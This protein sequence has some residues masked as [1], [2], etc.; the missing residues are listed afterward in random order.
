MGR[1]LRPR[2]IKQRR[3][4]WAEDLN[5]QGAGEAQRQR[6][7]AFAGFVSLRR[8]PLN[9]GGYDSGGAY[10]GHGAPLWSAMSDCGTVDIWTRARDRQAAKAEVLK[11]APKARFWR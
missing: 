6:E 7:A 2:S 10:W 5:E 11:V 3:D 8:I 9:A 4:A 1:R